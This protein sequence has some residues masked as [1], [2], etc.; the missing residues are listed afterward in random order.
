MDSGNFS[1]R[2]R[3]GRRPRAVRRI[4]IL[5]AVRAAAILGRTG[6]GSEYDLVIRGLGR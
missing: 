2:I 1:K 6:C 4:T 3:D 5:M